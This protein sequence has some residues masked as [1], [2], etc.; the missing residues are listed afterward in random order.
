LNEST[1]GQQKILGFKTAAQMME[2]SLSQ[3]AVYQ[4]VAL[5]S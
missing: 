2:K 5:T 4:S 1:I 3:M